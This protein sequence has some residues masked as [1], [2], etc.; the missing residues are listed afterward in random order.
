MTWMP[1]MCL[2]TGLLLGWRKLP[3]RALRA[4]DWLVNGALILLMAV[5]GMNVGINEE[6][7]QNLGKIGLNCALLCL[8]AIGGSVA[9]VVA[10][11]HTILPLSRLV[12][13]SQQSGGQDAE[14]SE[15]VQSK[16]PAEGGNALL[17]LI[18]L[19]VAAGIAAGY[20]MLTPASARLLDALLY[21]ALIVLYTGVG[22]SMGENRSVFAYLKQL[23]AKVLLLCLAIFFGS[24]GGGLLAGMLLGV[25]PKTALLASSGMGYYSMTGA[26]MTQHMGAE[27]GIYG[28]M[29][30]VMRDFFTVLLLPL[31]VHISKGSAIASGA[32]GNMDT[33]LVPVTKL[34]G[35]EL[36]LVALVAGVITTFSVP[37]LQPLLYRFL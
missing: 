13:L 7:M 11:E 37:F 5:I 28:F 19:S 36:G 8:S 15:A 10:L 17:W 30:N 18:P 24:V 29:V 34:V 2:G 35:Q 21:G 14:A 22:I 1:F 9:F 12:Q 23:G 33:M 4:V 16:A 6:I 25:A 31:L 27:A 32:A 20:F 3:A 26:F